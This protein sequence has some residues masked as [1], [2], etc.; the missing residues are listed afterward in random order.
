MPG[1]FDILM[2]RQSEPTEQSTDGPADMRS[3]FMR[4]IAPK[5]MIGMLPYNGS[6]GDIELPAETA[7]DPRLAQP[8]VGGQLL[9]SFR[10]M[11]DIAA[12]QGGAAENLRNA[13]LKGLGR[14]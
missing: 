5:D 6:L 14:K 8:N 12:G 2:G 13:G 9:K 3:W 11:N 7:S 10:T 1:L 4:M